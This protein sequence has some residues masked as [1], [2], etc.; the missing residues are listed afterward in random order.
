[1]GGVLIENVPYSTF[2]LEKN[3]QGQKISTLRSLLAFYI[4]T[5]KIYDL[6][7]LFQ[8]HRWK[9]AHFQSKRPPN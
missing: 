5:L 4:L 7:R 2:D 8:G 3:G 9:M 6:G 1:L